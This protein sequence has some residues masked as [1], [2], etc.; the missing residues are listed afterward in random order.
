M[1]EYNQ[2]QDCPK[3]DVLLGMKI[4]IPIICSGLLNLKSELV[5]V[6]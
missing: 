2:Q 3:A 5:S 1:S 4:I 6:L